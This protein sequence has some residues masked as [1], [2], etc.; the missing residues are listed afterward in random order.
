MLWPPLTNAEAVT[1]GGAILEGGTKEEAEAFIQLTFR[2]T[3]RM[4]ASAIIIA[5]NYVKGGQQ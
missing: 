2:P 4:R 3:A 5:P 1:I